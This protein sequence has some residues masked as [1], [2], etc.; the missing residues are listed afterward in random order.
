MKQKH[1]KWCH[2]NVRSRYEGEKGAKSFVNVLSV[3]C[4]YSEKTKAF[5][6]PFFITMS[7]FAGY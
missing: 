2:V 7:E 5:I 6:G 1:I 3:L 4:I